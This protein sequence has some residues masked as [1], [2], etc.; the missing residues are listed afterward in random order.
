M[1]TD[2]SA[3]GNRGKDREFIP[4]IHD[5]IIRGELL[6]YRNMQFV[7]RETWVESEHALKNYPGGLSYGD[8]DLVPPFA[9]DVGGGSEE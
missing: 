9:G 8:L 5:L 3:A 2:L 7:I 6:I 1:I 4:V